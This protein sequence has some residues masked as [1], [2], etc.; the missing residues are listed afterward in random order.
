VGS[1]RLWCWCWIQSLIDRGVLNPNDADFEYGFPRR[2]EAET[3]E[4]PWTK[5]FGGGGSAPKPKAVVLVLD[6]S[7]S[8]HGGRIRSATTNLAMVF[9][10]YTADDDLVAYVEFN[11]RVYIRHPMA[12][13]DPAVANKILAARPN[14]RTAFFDAMKQS[15]NML[16]TNPEAAKMDKYVILLTDG[17]DT[18]SQNQTGDLQQVVGM[19]QNNQNITPF[20]IGAG[21]DISHNSVNMMQT[22]TGD[23]KGP[24]PNEQIGGMYVAA[25]KTEEL[26]A[27]F[28]QVAQAMVGPALERL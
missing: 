6:V 1:P 13:K 14:N 27:A 25:E 20:I 9:E 15:I 2:L 18:I 26:E 24:R 19:L 10:K 7:G 23:A 17:D 8:M 16:V 4:P 22:I 3:I 12:R 21:G 11:N 5:G 28:E